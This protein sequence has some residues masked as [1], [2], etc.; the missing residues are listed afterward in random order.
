MEW[1]KAGRPRTSVPSTQEPGG[2]KPG[3]GDKPWTKDEL[4][5]IKNP[6]KALALAVIKQWKKDG[7]PKSDLEYI[8][9]WKRILDE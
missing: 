3:P 2:D 4:Q 5:V 9:V 8:E 7:C 6:V 1:N